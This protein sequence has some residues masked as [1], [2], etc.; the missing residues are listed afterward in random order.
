M[1]DAVW[2]ATIQCCTPGSN[3]GAA[4]QMWFLVTTQYQLFWQYRHGSGS[5]E[6]SVCLVDT[7][8]HH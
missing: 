5:E 1:A 2:V 8:T 4:I 7:H 6:V 3:P